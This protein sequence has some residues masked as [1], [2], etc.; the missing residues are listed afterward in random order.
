MEYPPINERIKKLIDFYA[1]GSVRKFSQMIGLSSSQKLNRLFHVDKRYGKYPEASY[2]IIRAIANKFDLIDANWILT[3]NGEMFKVNMDAP[4][5]NEPEIPY[6]NGNGNEY[7][8]LREGLYKVTVP[9]IPVN[10]YARYLTDFQEQDVLD[11]METVEFVVDQV[12]KGKYVA[13]EIKG[14]S[15]DDNTSR[16]IPDRSLVLARELK[17]DHWQNKLHLTRFPFWI[18]VHPNGILCKEIIEHKTGEGKIRCHSLNPSPEYQ[19][20]ELSLDEV[21]QLFNVVKIQKDVNFF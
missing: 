20:F 17:R 8:E 12:G 15:M 11:E 6:K 19:D 16:S 3:G 2:D 4:I 1:N 10:A 21:K 5:V 14:D 13:F 9:L 7:K 18:I